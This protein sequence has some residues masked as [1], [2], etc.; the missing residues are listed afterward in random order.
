M[1]QT[2]VQCLLSSILTPFPL[3]QAISSQAPS[4]FLGLFILP[5]VLRLETP[6]SDTK[7]RK[8]LK[9]TKTI[10]PDNV[11]TAHVVVLAAIS[12]YMLHVQGDHNQTGS[13]LGG[14]SESDLPGRL[15]KD[16]QALAA[17]AKPPQEE[18]FVVYER[19]S[20]KWCPKAN[21]DSCKVF[22]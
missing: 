2:E 10:Q 15:D 21:I 18:S 13:S 11:D 16:H 8:A 9:Q 17:V 6:F 7:R 12:T 22:G 19:G 14:S 5:A 1:G 3:S 4:L 20:H